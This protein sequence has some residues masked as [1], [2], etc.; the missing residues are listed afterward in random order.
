MVKEK[1]VQ[2][3][4]MS[5]PHKDNHIWDEESQI[6]FYTGYSKSSLRNDYVNALLQIRVL[7]KFLHIDLLQEPL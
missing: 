4:F 7:E 3:T 5:P 2:N 6:I 1:R